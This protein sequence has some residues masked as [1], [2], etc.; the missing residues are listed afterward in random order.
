[1]KAIKI[2]SRKAKGGRLERKWASLLRTF[3]LDKEARRMIGSGAFD[4]YKGDVYTKLPFVFECKN[5]ENHKIWQEFEQAQ[6]QRKPFKTPILVISGNHR[7]ILAVMLGQDFL[8]LLLENKQL[9][10]K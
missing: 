6:E 10:E 2:S 3:G 8:N 5:N 9:N 7:P 4:D 1:M